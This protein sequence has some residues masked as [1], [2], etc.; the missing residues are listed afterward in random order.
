MARLNST[1]QT[2][3]ARGEAARA[4]AQA[5]TGG[6]L[7][8][9]PTP[10]GLTATG[11]TG[12][13]RDALTQLFLLATTQFY[14]ENAYH[15][16][17]A[18]AKARLVG[19][20]H[21]VAVDPDGW[22][23]L[24]GFVPW[25]RQEANVRTAAIVIAL[26]AVRA[27]LSRQVDVPGVGPELAPLHGDGNRELVDAALQRPD[28]PGEALAYW[29]REHG[30]PIPK[31]IKRGI[32][33]AAGRLF[34]ERG[35]LR[36]DSEAHGVRFGDVLELTHSTGAT[37]A[38]GRGD[39]GRTWQDDLFRWS[40]TARQERD[41]EPPESLTS[42]RGRWS[43]NQLS[44][45]QRH[46]TARDALAHP[47][48]EWARVLRLA[49]A[50][51]WEWLHSWLGDEADVPLEV[52][53]GKADQWRLAL[54]QL[55]YMALLR[56]LRNLD[57]A[58]LPDEEVRPLM[59]RL[60]D[61][62]QVARSRQLPYRF[63]SAWLNTGST[64]WGPVLDRALGHSLGNV[65]VLDGTTLV[66]I[67]T[68]GSMQGRLSGKSQMTRVRAAAL[69]GFALALRQERGADVF[70]FADGQF[71]VTGISRGDSILRQL[72]VFDRSVG[73]VGHG[74]QIEAAV[75]ATFDV[76]RHARVVIFTDMQT[77]PVHGG[78]HR[79]NVA[80]AVPDAVPVYGFNLAGYQMSGMP[81]GTGNRH[82]LGGLTDH[83]FSLIQQLEA[84]GHGTWPWEDTVA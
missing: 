71:R 49:T 70:G 17:A 57:Q 59:K 27:R 56:N 54:P 39:V 44:T 21:Q 22:A 61:P 83:T 16:A 3:R 47:T 38:R 1:W 63:Y 65:P 8:A 13:Q 28:E 69:F 25:L 64:R 42:V 14:G 18:D 36:Y 41:A 62:E 29:L 72:D 53:V 12:Y 48:G 7:R 81:A 58:G 5:A 10:T 37:T 15:E 60:S 51:Q 66:L 79:G 76:Q 2:A 24:R 45:T 77:F 31:P 52:R 34:S 75:R 80:A 84:A 33:D 67:D 20:V 55:G 35:Y 6:P 50:G 40:I 23:W 32:A 73:R 78:Y 43:L 19:L 46:A 9:S 4:T 26:E 30:R 11:G 68:S 74:T 82:E